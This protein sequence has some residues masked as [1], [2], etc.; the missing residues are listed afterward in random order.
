MD[1]VAGLHPLLIQ[2]DLLI[3]MAVLISIIHLLSASAD[4]AVESRLVE[5][6]NIV[7]SP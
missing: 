4:Q 6:N 3:R 1:R 5:S 7:C 2:D